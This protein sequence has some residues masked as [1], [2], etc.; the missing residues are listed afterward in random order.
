MS[1][2]LA[3]NTT[4]MTLASVGQKLVAFLYFTL[5]ARHIGAA[6]TGIYFTALAVS[7]V[8]VV[9]VDVGLTNVFVREG[10]KSQSDLQTYLSNILS[11]KLLLGVVSYIGLFIA[12]HL[13]GYNIPLMHMIYLSGVTMLFDSF[14]LTLYGTLRAIGN[15]R[16]EAISLVASQIGTLVFGL[17]FL[18]FQLPLIFLILAFTIP[19]F[20]NVCFAALVLK[21]RYHI[22]VRLAWNTSIIRHMIKIVIPFALAAIFARIY[23]YIDSILLQRLAGDVAVGWY[24]IAYK[25]TYSFQFIPLAL[26]A[27]LYP[28]FSAYAEKNT[29]ELVRL[30]EQGIKYMMLVSFPVAIGI[31]LLARDIILTVYTTEYTNAILPLQILILSLVFSYLSFPI[32]ACLNACNKQA[33]QTTIV[34]FVMV[35]N[36]ILNA[37]FIPRYG[38]VA[39]AGAAFVGNML[40]TILGYISLPN[41]MAGSHAFFVKTG[42]QIA[43]AALVMGLC[44]WGVNMVLPFWVALIVGVVVYPICI[45]LFRAV[46]FLEV[47][48]TIAMIKR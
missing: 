44:V 39:A 30:F 1:G 13:L 25:I 5:I 28:K 12:V 35:V 21:F 42:L 36:I 20:L 7:T 19:S 46:T 34:G 45:F 33:R 40:L 18:Y 15:L 27:A 37:V 17:L 23:S 3:K 32:G 11:L 4:F 9:F 29:K 41:V 47:R 48:E 26:V 43:A 31:A 22:S 16:Y 6:D 2:S 8:A 10:S 38:V 14:H 24:A